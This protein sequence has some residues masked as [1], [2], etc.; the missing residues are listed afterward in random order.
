MVCVDFIVVNF[1]VVI[2]E[3]WDGICCGG[4]VKIVMKIMK[5]LL[6]CNIGTLDREGKFRSSS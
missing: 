3:I 1:V 2:V 6:I 4:L 5:L